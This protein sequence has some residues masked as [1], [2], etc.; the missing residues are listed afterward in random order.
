MV[1][2]LVVALTKWVREDREEQETLASDE[3]TGMHILCV[4]V[5]C[6]VD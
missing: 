1:Y 3:H 4:C 2:L 5:Y 6:Y